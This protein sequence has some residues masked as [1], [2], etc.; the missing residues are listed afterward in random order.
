MQYFFKEILSLLAFPVFLYF[1]TFYL[2]VLSGTAETFVHHVL[3][4]IGHGAVLL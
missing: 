4:Y 1:G 3:S 2:I